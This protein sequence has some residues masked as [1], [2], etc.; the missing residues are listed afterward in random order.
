MW[1]IV[2]KRKH[3][4]G[5]EWLVN[6]MKQE[7][8]NHEYTSM[9]GFVVDSSTFSRNITPFFSDHE[10]SI[11]TFDVLIP[12]SLQNFMIKYRRSSLVSVIQ[13]EQYKL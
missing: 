7:L 9:Y 1:K 4:C 10:Y 5:V 12:W 13:K 2:D 3:T 8:A 6:Q 11:I